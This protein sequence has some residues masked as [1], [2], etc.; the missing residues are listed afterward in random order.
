MGFNPKTLNS[1]SNVLKVK[2]VN[3]FLL[4]RFI[5]SKNKKKKNK[6]ISMAITIILMVMDTTHIRS[7]KYNK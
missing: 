4:I 7:C 6:K 2:S 5:F 3:N 1:I